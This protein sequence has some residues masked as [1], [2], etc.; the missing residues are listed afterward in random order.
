MKKTMISGFT[1]LTFQWRK[2]EN[3]RQLRSDGKK[4]IGQVRSFI[5]IIREDLSDNKVA[6]EQRKQFV[7]DLRL[8]GKRK[9]KCTYSFRFINQSTVKEYGI[10]VGFLYR[11]KNFRL[12]I[13][14]KK[15]HVAVGK[16]SDHAA[17]DI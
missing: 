10:K 12:R 5:Q 14:R 3:K 4:K 7:L 2:Q 9:K 1:E 17:F 16:R 13:W 8:F 15:E 6:F 11:N